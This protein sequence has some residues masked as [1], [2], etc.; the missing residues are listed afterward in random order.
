MALKIRLVEERIAELYPTDNIQSPVHLSIGQETVAVGV[1][2]PLRRTD[3]LFCSYRSHAFYIAK[4]G[5][6]PKMFGELYGKQAGCAG[7]KG[8]SMHLAAPEV[9]LMGASAVVASTIPHA[10]GAALAARNH[11][12]DQV[13]VAVFGDGATEEGVYHESLNFAALHE[14]PIVF[15]CENNGLAVHSR[16]SERQSYDIVDHARSY[17]L[18]V[19]DFGDALDFEALSDGFGIVVAAVRRTRTLHFAHA[20]TFRYKEHVG[21]GEDFD[22]GY[23]SR[24]SMEAWRKNDPLVQNRAL[25]ERFAPSIKREIDA[26]VAFAESAAWPNAQDLLTHV[27]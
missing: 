8:G 2:E 23:R 15:L 26:A 14:L 7:G 17:G 3:L 20:R 21:P 10:V 27:V 18:P 11:K 24:E 12:N 9:G 13:I 19:T 5:D 16:L 22:A 25:V 1:C 4:G 6:L